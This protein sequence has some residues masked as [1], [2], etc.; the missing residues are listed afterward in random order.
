MP[1]VRKLVVARRYWFAR[2]KDLTDNQEGLV[3]PA[4]LA[5][6]DKMTTRR[7]KSYGLREARE[8][9]KVALAAAEAGV[10]V[11]KRSKDRK[12]IKAAWALVNA[13]RAELD[14]LE[15]LMK[16]YPGASTSHRGTASWWPTAAE[17][18]VRRVPDHDDTRLSDGKPHPV[19]VSRRGAA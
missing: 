13:R 3:D 6:V 19:T 4:Y 16:S 12:A 11:A 9:A 17:D 7:E 10:D 5:V 1:G 15:R 8:A 18:A 2:D 14:R